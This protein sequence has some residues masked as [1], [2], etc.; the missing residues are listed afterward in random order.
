MLLTIEKVAIL[1]GMDI[2]AG[3][4]GHLLAAVAQIAEEV[5]LHPG[6]ALI[7]EGA[8]ED[9]LYVVIEGQV[10]VHSNGQTLTTLGPGHSVG[11]LAL[12]DPEPRSASVN[13][14]G[15]VRLFRIDKEPFAEVML[16]RPEIAQGIMRALARR[17]R[18]LTQMVTAKHNDTTTR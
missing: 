9:C 8:L 7:V 10:R 14:V 5:E 4:P 3:T 2:F 6:E 18:E 13:A 15:E 12:L 17:I 16:R 11:E 1:Q